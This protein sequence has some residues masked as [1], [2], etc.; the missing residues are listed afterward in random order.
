MID[1]E[2]DLLH[3]HSQMYSLHF[4]IEEIKQGDEIAFASSVDV[5]VGDEDEYACEIS[6]IESYSFNRGT[7]PQV[8][9]SSYQFFKTKREPI[10]EFYLCFRPRIFH[11]DV[12]KENCKDHGNSSS[13]TIAFF[14]ITKYECADID[15]E[16]LVVDIRE[17]NP[18]L[19]N[20][21]ILPGSSVSLTPAYYDDGDELQYFKQLSIPTFTIAELFPVNRIITLKRNV[22]EPLDDTGVFSILG[23]G[24][25]IGRHYEINFDRET[26]ALTK[27]SYEYR[28]VNKG[29][30]KQRIRVYDF[31]ITSINIEVG[32]KKGIGNLFYGR[33]TLKGKNFLMFELDVT[34]NGYTLAYK[35]TSITAILS[36]KNSPDTISPLGNLENEPLEVIEIDNDTIVIDNIDFKD[37]TGE[38]ILTLDIQRE[39]ICIK[40]S[41]CTCDSLKIFSENPSF[42]YGGGILKDYAIG[43]VTCSSLCYRIDNNRAET[44]CIVHPEYNKPLEDN[45][46]CTNDCSGENKYIRMINIEGAMLKQC[47]NECFPNEYKTASHSGARKIYDTCEPCDSECISCEGGGPA[48]CKECDYGKELFTE[49]GEL[50]LCVDKLEDGEEFCKDKVEFNAEGYFDEYER[51]GSPINLI[52]TPK[53][54]YE[55]E[56]IKWEQ[57][58]D[59]EKHHSIFVE[60]TEITTRANL[61]YRFILDLKPD[62]TPYFKAT[63]TFKNPIQSKCIGFLVLNHTLNVK[64]SIKLSQYQ[65]TV[66]ITPFT[67]Y[68]IGFTL[69]EGT[70]IRSGLDYINRTVPLVN[71]RIHKGIYG[72]TLSFG[73]EGTSFFYGR[74][75]KVF[76]SWSYAYGVKK[77]TFA[78]RTV[79]QRLNEKL[80]KNSMVTL[81]NEYNLNEVLGIIRELISRKGGEGEIQGYMKASMI[82]AYYAIERSKEE[83][84]TNDDCKQYNNFALCKILNYFDGKYCIHDNNLNTN[85]EKMEKELR[86][87]IDVLETNNNVKLEHLAVLVKNMAFISEHFNKDLTNNL[88]RAIQKPI[89]RTLINK[90]KNLEQYEL[91]E[92]IESFTNLMMIKLKY[93]KSENKQDEID[94]LKERIYAILNI[95]FE[96][97]NLK[98]RVRI[99]NSN[100][101]ASIIKLTENNV[102]SMDEV[103]AIIPS[104]L[105][106][107]LKE[108]AKVRMIKWEKNPYNFIESGVN[109][110]SALVGL[111][112]VKADSTVIKWPNEVIPMIE[113]II[114]YIPLANTR[115]LADLTC[116]YYNTSEKVFMTNGCY[117]IEIVGNNAVCKVEHLT[118]FG[119]LSTPYPDD[120]DSPG[121]KITIP[122]ETIN[123]KVLFSLNHIIGIKILDS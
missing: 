95:N 104:S 101:K 31:D 47:T 75:K 17:F 44:C 91:E 24:F 16:S 8:Y 74:N 116:V 67:L 20:P 59:G 72:K 105:L 45:N 99:T 106:S 40:P 34:I 108:Q 48:K 6:G 32:L 113:P 36:F 2:K 55:V 29:N 62:T 76:P 79:I 119:I 19:N 97:P 63:I 50:G 49:D 109:V 103:K 38:L 43:R 10:N 88:F 53:S 96:N 52:A 93:S 120:E 66:D 102:Y 82:L 35:T 83:C 73:N 86:E 22:L 115:E 57:V 15:A 92:V 84:N 33:V 11:P 37:I 94:T 70:T 46:K 117:M 64:A 27:D 98:E 4:D 58:V 65:G 110:S 90:A 71:K 60:G 78:V 41:P 112:F 30:Y 21:Y 39:C 1:P 111:S 69:L 5:D 23:T 51:G 25:L 118:D 13:F 87:F 61:T 56:L 18:P 114:L 26:F 14:K 80:V 100:F 107:Y 68:F 9:I 28:F 89:T 54:G 122:D 121:G 77:E 81:E 12:C 85:I 123:I 3:L 42:L 7:F